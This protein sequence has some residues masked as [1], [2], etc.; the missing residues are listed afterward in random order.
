MVVLKAKEI[1]AFDVDNTLL[2]WSEDFAT[3]DKKKIKL[4]YGD[5]DVYLEE[6]LFHPTFLKHCHNRGDFIIVW[7]QNGYF[8][9]EQVVKKL[10]LEDY[11]HI[12]MSKPSRHVDDKEELK[13][14]VGN[15]I[16]IPQN[17]YS[18]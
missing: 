16:Y 14:I 7:S 3:K 15:R 13:D 9:A 17:K 18:E 8:W 5:Q 6:H 12:V 4:Q 11:V 10:G 2:M 1:T